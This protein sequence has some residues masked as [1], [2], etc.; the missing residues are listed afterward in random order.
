MSAEVMNQ[1]SN[2][3]RNVDQAAFA[4]CVIYVAKRVVHP[5]AMLTTE[6]LLKRLDARGVAN[7]QIADAIGVS[8]SRV[9]EMYK[10]ERA[11]KLDE[12]VKLVAA[13]DLESEPGL[14]KES[15]L[16]VPIA[17]LVVRYVASALGVEVQDQRHILELAEDIRAFAEFVSDPKVRQSL[18]AAEAFFAA[19]RLRR[20]SPQEEGQRQNDPLESR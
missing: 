20:P 5:P 8:P 14:E 7:K 15:P 12:A 16:P 4:E 2:E 19:M 1:P 6:E 11:I 3:N 10:G 17:R 13:F 9:T 18:V